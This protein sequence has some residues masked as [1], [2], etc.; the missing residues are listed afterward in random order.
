M[1]LPLVVDFL[2]ETKKTNAKQYIKMSITKKSLLLIFLLILIDQAS[3]FYVKLNFQL[4]ESVDVFSWFR[5]TF[6]E[7]NGMAFGMELFGKLF[8]TLF[9]IAAVVVLA[10]YIHKMIKRN[11]RTGYILAVSMLLAGAAG[12][13]VDSLFYG[14]IFNESTPV[15][16]ASFMPDSG[17]YAPFLY[18]K[19]VDMFYFP[20]IS[21]N[22][23]E[24]IFFRYIFN[25]A[26]ACV[27]VSVV[28]ILLFFR[29]EL[30]ESLESKKVTENSDEK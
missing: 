16:I 12:N 23:G 13:I 8:L 2:Y 7:N 21:D 20:I 18:G 28:I 3:K 29:K 6:V 26:D 9:R 1:T 27:T 24:T 14:V 15:Q 22:A 10:V 30:N 25:V 4:G 19:V 11:A 5:I 17:G